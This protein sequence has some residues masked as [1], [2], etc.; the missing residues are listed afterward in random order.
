MWDA[1][2]SRVLNYLC[3]DRLNVL[4]HNEIDNDRQ[5]R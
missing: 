2:I 1:V 4:A 3:N 5:K